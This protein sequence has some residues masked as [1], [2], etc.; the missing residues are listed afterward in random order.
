MRIKLTGMPPWGL[1]DEVMLTAAVCQYARV[2]PRESI[3]VEGSRWPDIWSANPHVI[4]QTRIEDNGKVFEIHAGG[5]NMRPGPVH[6]IHDFCSILDVVASDA[7]PEMGIPQ[8]A[9]ERARR[10]IDRVTDQNLDK[11]I[12]TLHVHAG[13]PIRR[14]SKWQELV[15]ALRDAYHNEIAIIEVGDQSG[16]CFGKFKD[17]NLKN[18]DLSLVDKKLPILDTAAILWDSDLF[19]GVDS[20]PAQLASAVGTNAIVL[21]SAGPYGRLSNSWIHPVVVPGTDCVNDC[22]EVCRHDRK[23]LDRITVEDVMHA[24]RVGID[25]ASG[26]DLEL[27]A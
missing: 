22:V 21:Y 2:H 1:G 5:E 19:I 14:W 8:E 23:C 12:V 26:K 4:D 25:Q 10:I 11:V 15:D 17:A 6:R 24:V 13:W 16:D 9:I 27:E 3:M 18:I 20:G 7:M